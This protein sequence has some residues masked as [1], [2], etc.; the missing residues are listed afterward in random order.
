MSKKLVIAN[1]KMNPTRGSDAKKMFS[2]I[3]TVAS[4][5]KNVE[6][7]ICPPLI[8]LESLG[9]VVK[10]RSC[11]I[12]AQDAFWEHSGSFTGQVS[13][14]MVFNARARYVLV[15]HSER[16]AMGE[17]DEE[18]NRKIRSILQFPLIPVVC[19]GEKKRDEES[20]Y[21]KELKMQIKNSLEGLTKE[22]LTRVVIAYEPVWA[23][24]AK[25]KRA[26]TPGECREIVQ[27][28]RQVLADFIGDTI[29]A[30]MVP[31]LYGGSVTEK[32]AEGFFQ[33]GLVNGVLV[34]RASLEPK[35]FIKILKIAEKL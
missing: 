24:G 17:T 9:E 30:R 1:W 12:G 32:E 21:V 14:D 22:E 19:V 11:V 34:G 18:V 7:V 20:H 33:D 26:C 3:N 28:I 5:L 8:Y 16:R 4:K 15:G 25:S 2:A 31:V 35:E 13:P 6:T 10:S 23:I 29:S 27:V